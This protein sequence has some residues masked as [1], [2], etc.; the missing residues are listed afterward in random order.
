M[1]VLPLQCS[2]NRELLILCFRARISGLGLKKNCCYCWY[3]YLDMLKIPDHQVAGH[4]AG[5]GKLGPLIDDSGR[6]CKPL[7]NDE[8]GS[9]EAAFYTSFPLI[10]KF[11]IKSVSTSRFSM[12]LEASDGSGLH[13]HLI[14]EDLVSTR[15]HPSLMDIKIGSRTWYAQASEEYI[16]KI[17]GLQA[18]ES[19]ESGFWKPAKKVVSS[20]DVEDVR[21]SLKRFVSSNPLADAKPDGSFGS[22]VYGG[23]DG[24]LAQLLELKA[25][26]EDQTIYHFNSC[27]VL[28]MYEKAGAE[29]GMSRVEVKLIDFAHVTDGEG[30]ID[31]NFL[32]GLCSLIKFL[33]EI[34]VNLGDYTI[35]GGLNGFWQAPFSFQNGP[36]KEIQ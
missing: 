26:F 11:Q 34:L 35:E 28:V 23:S 7:Q 5:D 31:H 30:V 25:C 4:R 3:N 1:F 32:G 12:L 2:D 15:V 21:S 9:R 14:L 13:P 27:S 22:V 33:S 10:L 24:I 18:Y 19:E 8:R 16:K 17:S 20:Y 29:T 6:F 36:K